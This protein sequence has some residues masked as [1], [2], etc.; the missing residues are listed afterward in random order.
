M[1]PYVLKPAPE[2]YNP[3]PPSADGDVVF[4]F[5]RLFYERR[6]SQKKGY[7]FRVEQFPGFSTSADEVP[8]LN[9][10]LVD[11]KPNIDLLDGYTEDAEQMR[12]DRNS[13][14]LHSFQ[15]AMINFNGGA[16]AIEDNGGLGRKELYECEFMCTRASLVHIGLKFFDAR[17][18]LG[19][20]AV[21]RS[22]VIFLHEITMDGPSEFA[23][24]DEYVGHRFR[25]LMTNPEDKV[26]KSVTSFE[27]EH[28]GIQRLNFRKMRILCRSVVDCVTDEESYKYVELKTHREKTAGQ[29]NIS[30]LKSVRWWLQM[31]FTGVDDLV[32]G[33]RDYNNVLRKT[34]YAKSETFLSPDF[35]KN[36]VLMF[37]EDCL[38]KIQLHMNDVDEGIP[39]LF[40]SPAGDINLYLKVTDIDH[41]MF[42]PDFEQLL[43]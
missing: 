8:L 41:Q 19:L 2:P 22:G 26:P 39:R 6:S 14:L 43:R 24:Q 37:T 21:Q 20:V 33:S 18:T 3:K 30:P 23:V 1:A 15:L 16:K 32:V 31:K 35:N 36:A 17:L 11:A 10:A 34:Q 27:D 4:R 7:R 29:F 12:F 40:L 25:Q 13:L 5:N 28:F 42:H 38:T 9:S